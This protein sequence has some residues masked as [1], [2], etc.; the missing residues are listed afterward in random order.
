LEIE[1]KKSL[2]DI[3]TENTF[4]I[5]DI[6]PPSE[7]GVTFDD[8]GALENVKDTLKELVMLPF[9]WPELFCKGQLTKVVVLSAFGFRKFPYCFTMS[10][11][12]LMTD[13]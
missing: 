10:C 2:K 5:S 4:E 8:I 13:L 6:I 11:L 3:V 12:E 1:S 9:Q 7:I